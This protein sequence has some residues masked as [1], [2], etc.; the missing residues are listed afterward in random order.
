MACDR[1]ITALSAHAHGVVLEPPVAAHLAVCS[2]CQA[3]L[4]QERELQRIIEGSIE[5]VVA[6]EPPADFRVRLTARV[7]GDATSFQLRTYLATAAV[8]ALLVAG[9]WA[10]T[11]VR[12]DRRPSPAVATVAATP[13][14][15]AT[16][17]PVAAPNVSTADVRQPRRVEVV[18]GSRPVRAVTPEFVVLVPDGQRESLGRFVAS[19]SQQDP[20]VASRL[21]GRRGATEIGTAEVSV[22][23]VMIQPVIVPDLPTPNPILEN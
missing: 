16:T 1:F 23:T 7:K 6:V 15:P 18:R 22:S 3:W 10:W 12:V 14:V 11:R 5:S 21:I 4:A 2:S 9:G 19:L 17:N 20:G 8:L 13:T